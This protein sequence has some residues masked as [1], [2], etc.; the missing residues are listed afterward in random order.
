MKKLT[1]YLF[2]LLF[3]S[4]NKNNGEVPSLFVMK[5][6]TDGQWKVTNFDKAGINKTT[7]FSIYTF[8]FKVNLTVDALNA[9]SLEK[10]GTWTADGDAKTISSNFVNA[11]NTLTLLNGTWD[12][13]NTTWTS[14]DATQTVN[15]EVFTLHL[16]KL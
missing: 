13:L 5:A 12:I 16:E 8:Q 1:L 10:T 2:L 4:C 14:V 9:G 6:M 3:I 11:S 7:D 15:G